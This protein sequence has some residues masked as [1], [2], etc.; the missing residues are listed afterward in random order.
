MA[1]IKKLYGNTWVISEPGRFSPVKMYLLAGSEKA[2]LIDSGYGTLDLETLVRGVYGGPVTIL[3][4]HGHLDHVGG[5]RFFPSYMPKEDID[6]YAR[7]SDPEFL[8]GMK[9][10]VFPR[11]EAHAIDFERLDLGGR[12]LEIIATPGHTKGSVCVLDTANK[13]IFVGDTFNFI[14][15]W[16]GTEDSTS[17]TEYKSSLEKLIQIAK[18]YG[19]KDFHSGHNFGAMHMKTLQNYRHCCEIILASDKKQKW[20]DMG[21]NKGY[22]TRYRLSMITWQ[23]KESQQTRRQ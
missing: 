22:N 1:K 18:Q 11:A 8:K 6:L 13:A 2:V 9:L 3:N 7:H 16:L 17:V 23:R 10:H 4:T 21:L 19:I 5:N 12:V 15:T 14:S 20:V